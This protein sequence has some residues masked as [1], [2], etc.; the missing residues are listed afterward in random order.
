MHHEEFLNRLPHFSRRWVLK[1][2]AVGLG[3]GTTS[4]VA[5]RATADESNAVA[6]FPPSSKPPRS[7]LFIFLTGGLSHH[8]SFDMKPEAPTETEPETE[9]QT[10][11]EPKLKPRQKP[12]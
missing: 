4:L 2:G 1:V 6:P 12:N 11:T 5:R 7:V 3:F 9:A 10:A 8:D